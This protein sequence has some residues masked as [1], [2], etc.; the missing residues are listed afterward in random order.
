MVDIYT[1]IEDALYNSLTDTFKT[2]GKNIEVIISHEGGTEPIK[3]YVAINVLD[4]TQTGGAS[5]S[6]MTQFYNNQAKEYA[7]RHYDSLVQ[8]S[9]FGSDS[10]EAAMLFHTQWKSNTVVREHFMRNK[11][12]PRTISNLRRA[13][14]LRESVWVKSFAMDI[15]V[16]FAVR[17][18]QDVDWADYITINGNEIPLSQQ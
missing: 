7:V 16:G 14:Q 2:L 4:M 10:S 1:A 13:P 6:G 18:I 11:L 3:N 5:K 15:R 17:T 8:L 12:A 9:F